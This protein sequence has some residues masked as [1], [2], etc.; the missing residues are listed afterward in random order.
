[1]RLRLVPQIL[2]A[3]VFVVAALIAF[4]TNLNSYFLSDDFAQIGKVL[5]GDYSFVW[6]QAHGG[7]FRPLFVVSYIIDSRIWHYQPFGY[8][9]TNV[10]LHALNS[11]LVFKVGLLLL[12]KATLT[13]RT[14][15][16]G[17][18]AAAALFLV[19]P[20][21]TEAV[22][23]ISG[24][25]DLL[26]TCFVLIALWQ[27]LVYLDQAR[28][29]LNLILALSAGLAA[30]LAKESAICLPFLIVVVGVY[31]SRGKKVVLEFGVFALV[32]LVFIL[33]RAAALGAVVGGYGAAQ[34]LN[35]GAGWI[36]D[37]VLEA[38]IRSALPALPYSWSSFLHKPLQSPIFFVVVTGF[39]ALLASAFI[40]R[41]RQYHRAQKR[42]QNGFVILL[43][44]LFLLSLLPAI[45]LRL[46]LYES[47]GE[48]FLYLP[49]V[50]AC[51]LMS[52]VATVLVRNPKIW[53]AVVIVVLG[54]YSWR[55]HATNQLW[56]QASSLTKSLAEGLAVSASTSQLTIINAP[57]NLRGV[58]VFHNGLPEALRL[59]PRVRTFAEV[60][61]NAFQRL[62]SATDVNQ[63][64]TAG[65]SV[66][67]E[68]TDQRD[69][70]DR[71]ASVGCLDLISSSPIKLEL[72]EKYC[73]T[74]EIFYFSGGIF[75]RL[76]GTNPS[77]LR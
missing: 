48:R 51:L 70:F 24:R 55:L 63:I 18:A 12:S 66:S 5:N 52:Y 11:F 77:G 75:H 31:R 53:L 64:E 4:S 67:I 30:L 17:A 62:Q 2:L 6:G 1:M 37:R 7:F 71:P 61:I 26:A 56:R 25:A 40:I 10:F 59:F 73:G 28:R 68:A 76:S 44:V 19:H 15:R 38:F 34:H 8:H 49:T 23:W 33:V 45:N 32:L 46:G 20:S 14:V 16:A 60:D 22:N 50:F 27:Y 41:A 47:L 35:F 3:G 57:D 42:T 65:G 13:V 36:R 43:L 54:F 9:L 39:C 21:H 69:T 74:A 58:P 72:Q 29:P